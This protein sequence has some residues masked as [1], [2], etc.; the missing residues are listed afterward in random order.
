MHILAHRGFWRLKK[1]KNSFQAIARAVKMGF[2]VETDVR[3]S[4]RKLVIAHDPG[5]SSR[6]DAEK[7]FELFAAD[8][9]ERT[10]AV[11]VKADGLQGLIQNLARRFRVR[12]YFIFD[13]SVP[14]LVVYRDRKIPFFTRQ[15]EFEPRPVLWKEAAGV[16]LDAFE[17]DWFTAHAVEEHV[18]AGKDVCV[19]S[20]EL[21]GREH[22]HLWRL[23]KQPGL[24]RYQQRLFLCTDFP[25]QADDFFNGEG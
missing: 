24:R 25:D 10:L 17:S 7:V 3:D 23:L 22:G 21:H 12:H 2:G 6:L 19:V 13:A 11:N 8:T 5:L 14:E 18:K 16:W 1:E 4:G 15:S 20:P 9:G